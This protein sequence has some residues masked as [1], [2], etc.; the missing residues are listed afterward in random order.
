MKT[1]NTDKI[2]Q[3]F[4]DEYRTLLN[5]YGGDSLIPKDEKFIVTEKYRAMCVIR[6]NGDVADPQVLSHYSIAGTV[7]RMLCGESAV[8]EAIARKQGSKD[9]RKAMTE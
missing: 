8:E 9:K 3:E 1:I 7:I 5:K 6:I 2:D 4:Q